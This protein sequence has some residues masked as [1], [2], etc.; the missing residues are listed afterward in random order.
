MVSLAT[1]LGLDDAPGMLRGYGAL[2]AATIREIV[3]VAEATGATTRL[4]G[5]FCDPVDGRLLA[6]ESA[7]K[8][9]TGGLRQFCAWRDQT[10]RLTGSRLSDID[11]VHPRSDHGPTTAANGQ[12]LGILTNRVIKQHP[13]VTV[14]TL[15]PVQRGDGLDRLPGPRPRHRMDPALRP[16]PH[17][18]T[19]TRPRTRLRPRRRATHPPLGPR[20]PLH[21]LPP[22]RRLKP[23]TRPPPALPGRARIPGAGEA[24]RRDVA[25][26]EEER[27]RIR[28]RRRVTR[29]IAAR[30]PLHS[31]ARSRRL[32]TENSAG[33]PPSPARGRSRASRWPWMRRSGNGCR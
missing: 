3:E 21:R 28:P 11:H 16:H 33:Q 27:T 4:R 1:V 18:H 17:P 25:N 10:D 14:H 24:A 5:L 9:F 8:L 26:G 30:R 19:P 20:R 6:M 22:S 15:P 13:D 12:G 32:T 31:H 7:A 29:P 23:R 2:P